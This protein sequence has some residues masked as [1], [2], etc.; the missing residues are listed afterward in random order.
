MFCICTI[1]LLL[2]VISSFFVRIFIVVYFFFYPQRSSET[3]DSLDRGGCEGL[4]RAALR[5]SNPPPP[6]LFYN[7]I[8]N[9]TTT[10]N[11]TDTNITVSNDELSCKSLPF[12]NLKCYLF[13]KLVSGNS[14]QNSSCAQLILSLGFTLDPSLI[15]YLLCKST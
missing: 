11:I 10:T 5:L 1:F 14:L 3:A 9:I 15:E 7:K 13:Q 2:A 12:S 4:L 6:P 8:I